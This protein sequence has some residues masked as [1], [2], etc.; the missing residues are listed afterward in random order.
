MTLGLLGFIYY[1]ILGFNFYT[2]ATLFR[3]DNFSVVNINVATPWVF[4]KDLGFFDQTLG[5][6]FF[7]EYLGILSRAFKSP[8]GFL[9]LFKFSWEKM[10]FLVVF[11][12][13]KEL[14]IDFIG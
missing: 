5:S 6:G 12:K 8:W 3:K 7:H 4:S 13:G 14:L 11:P 2:V 10:F 1:P 9:G